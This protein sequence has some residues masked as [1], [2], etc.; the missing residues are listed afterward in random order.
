MAEGEIYAFVARGRRRLNLIITA[1]AMARALVWAAGGA[2]IIVL[3]GRRLGCFGG[4]LLPWAVLTCLGGLIGLGMGWRQRLDRAGAARWLDRRL[5]LDEAISAALFCLERGCTGS[6]DDGVVARAA[7][8]STGK[9]SIRWPMRYLAHWSLLA[10]GLLILTGVIVASWRP[11]KAASANNPLLRPTARQSA[12]ALAG[13]IPPAVQSPGEAARLLFAQDPDLARQAEQALQ[14]GDTEML[15]R[16]LNAADRKMQERIDQ[17]ATPAERRLLQQERQRQR[18]MGNALIKGESG[19]TAG[20][21]DNQTSGKGA[22]QRPDMTRTAARPG[23]ATN[24]G[25]PHPGEEEQDP[26]RRRQDF[27]RDP[28]ITG[29]SANRGPGGSIPTGGISGK[30]LQAGRGAGQSRSQWGEIAGKS[31]RQQAVIGRNQQQTLEY[32]LPGKNARIPLSLAVSEA[33]RA[34]EGAFARASVPLEYLASVRAYFLALSKATTTTP[35]GVQ[36]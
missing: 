24:P 35:K 32:V 6:L 21:E 8:A 5:G 17:A 23:A 2:G 29:S 33:R 10:V 26:D 31:G 27:R 22:G 11:G 36:P 20:K 13:A 28:G 34:A 25:A 1:A 15:Q 14:A 18:E 4:T 30:G 7:A 16:L 12:E 9:A 19:P 3:L